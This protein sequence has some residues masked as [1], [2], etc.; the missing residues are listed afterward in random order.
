MHIVIKIIVLILG[1][2]L[3]TAC[4]KYNFQLTRLFGY[5]SLAEK[6]LGDGGTYSMWRLIGVVVIIGSLI[7]VFR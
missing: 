4:L 6:Y 7:Y 3:G 2:T 1:L 5:N